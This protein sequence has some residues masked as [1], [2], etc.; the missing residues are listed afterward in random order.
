MLMHSTQVELVGSQS[1]SPVQLAS[2]THATHLDVVRLQTS[3][4]VQSAS[5]EQV[6]SPVPL[7]LNAKNQIRKA[8]MIIATMTA[9]MIPTIN[10]VLGFFFSS[11][12]LLLDIL[13]RYLDSN[14]FLKGE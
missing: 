7:L 1:S 4:V 9:I 8:I 5:A 6:A 3:P 10:P 13:E 2:V 14:D 12:L 11:G